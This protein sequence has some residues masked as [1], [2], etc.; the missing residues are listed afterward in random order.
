MTRGFLVILVAAVVAAGVWTARSTPAGLLRSPRRPY[1][2]DGSPQ[3]RTEGLGYPRYATGADDVRVRIDRPARR[4]VSQHAQVDEYLYAVVPAERVV[5]VSET[6]YEPR[7]SNVSEHVARHHP[8]IANDPERVLLANPDLVITAEA[9]RAELPDLLRQAGLPVYRMY[10]M[11]ETLASVEDHIRLI[12]YLTG[13]DA[14]ADIETV[15]F[16]AVVTQAAARRPAN[17]AAP[18]VLGFGLGGGYSF[19]SRTLFNDILRVLGAENVS[20]THGV[21]G[22]DRASDERIVRWNPDWIVA[23]ADPGMADRTRANLLARPSIAETDAARLGH[24][25]VLDNRIFLPLSPYTSRLI[26][27]LSTA[28]YGKG[29]T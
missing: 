15:R 21:V 18:R 19:G 20:A 22:Y 27:A 17:M 7:L 5:G 10:T 25:V 13:E 3:V 24:I 28:L 11:F 8:I 16:R 1:Q 29:P 23:S 6:A 4:I 2:S 26:D 9:V 12:G 14:R